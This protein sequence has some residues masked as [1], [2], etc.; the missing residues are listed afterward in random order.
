MPPLPR[1]YQRLVGSKWTSAEP[2]HGWRHFE[3]T[4]VR[5]A[6]E[7]PL[8]QL[9]ASCASDTVRPVVDAASLFDRGQW[10]PGWTPLT[11]LKTP[12][13]PEAPPPRS[14]PDV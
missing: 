7:G 3:V 8:A 4:E 10:T 2:F 12:E 11:T 14:W 1:K 9:V 13:R 6:P 5:R